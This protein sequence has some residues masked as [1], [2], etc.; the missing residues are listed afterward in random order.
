MF[1]SQFLLH[2]FSMELTII[3]QSIYCTTLQHVRWII[4][5]CRKTRAEFC[6]INVFASEYEHK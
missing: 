1:A 6:D 5:T 4:I 2:N 3:V